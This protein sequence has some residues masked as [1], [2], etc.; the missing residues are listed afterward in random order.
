MTLT[1]YLETLTVTQGRRAGE[2]FAVLPWQ[3][4]FVRGG[5]RAGRGN[6]GAVRRPRERENRLG[7]RDRVRRARR[8]AHG[9]KGRDDHRGVVIRAGVHRV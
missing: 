3:R 6:G 9:P 5:V 8:A 2:P 4:R 1:E 7:G